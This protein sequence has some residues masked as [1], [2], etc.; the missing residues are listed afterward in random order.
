MWCDRGRRSGLVSVWR[1]IGRQDTPSARG[2]SGMVLRTRARAHRSAWGM[3]RFFLRPEVVIEPLGYRP[4]THLGER[5]A[6]PPCLVTGVFSGTGIARGD[7]VGYQARERG[8][9]RQE[10]GH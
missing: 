9:L 1:R 5:L 4:G 8:A 3:G 10:P 6:A 7:V 2:Q